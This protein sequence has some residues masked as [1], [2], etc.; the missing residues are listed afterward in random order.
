[1]RTFALLTL[2]TQLVA[3][4]AFAPA[5]SS[6]RVSPTKQTAATT[7]LSMAGG[8]DKQDEDF[9]KW[10]RASRCATDDDVVVELPRPL[11]LILNQDPNG[12]VYVE[13][14][15]PKGNAA[16]TGQVGFTKNSICEMHCW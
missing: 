6:C 3:V 12:N 8:N 4:T 9:M 15:A 11:G 1:M 14:V 13:P 10:A 7:A 2:L 5:L 16:R